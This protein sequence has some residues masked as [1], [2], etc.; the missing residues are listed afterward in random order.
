M[1]TPEASGVPDGR[2]DA[3]AVLGFVLVATMQVTNIVLAR[4]LAVTVPPF[5][6]AFFR[7]M[8]IAAGLAPFAIADYGADACLSRPVHFP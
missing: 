4:G 3:I 1:L 5:T 8:I 2:S 6:L 7:W